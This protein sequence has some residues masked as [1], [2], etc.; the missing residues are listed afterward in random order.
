MWFVHRRKF[1]GFASC[2]HV[3]SVPLTPPLPH[4]TIP[5]DFTPPNPTAERISDIPWKLSL[6]FLPFHPS[7]AFLPPMFPN[8]FQYNMPYA[9][10]PWIFC[11][12]P[13]APR[14]IIADFLCGNTYVLKYFVQR[15]CMMSKCNR[16]MV[17]KAL[18]YQHMTIKPTHFGNGK[19]SN[20][21]KRPRRNRQ[22]L[23]ICNICAQLGVSG[24]L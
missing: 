4:S 12:I 24:W 2:R 7:L 10:H 8:Q 17:R 22:Y 15:L 6:L 3:R 19:H 9:L 20:W 16:A 14:L 13:C 18:F 5:A 1:R 21:T 23:S 11:R